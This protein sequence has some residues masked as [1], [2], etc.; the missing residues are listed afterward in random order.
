MS[1]PSDRDVYVSRCLRVA[2]AAGAA[3]LTLRKLKQPA[4]EVARDGK[5]VSFP[6]VTDPRTWRDTTV[7]EAFY[8]VL[9]DARGWSAAKDTLNSP[10]ALAT[11]D[12]TEKTEIPLMRKD[13]GDELDR[14]KTLAEMLGGEDKLD[15]L[16][17]TADLA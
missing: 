16:Y 5:A 7:E 10:V 4:L 2:A 15:S 9:V 11:L 12:E 17:A 8:V 6:I 3:G 14:V 13:L 1:V